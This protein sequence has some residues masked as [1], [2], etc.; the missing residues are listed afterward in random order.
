MSATATKDSAVQASFA[1]LGEVLSKYG[2]RA[3]A[4]RAWDGSVWE[5]EAGQSARFT[6]VLQH[7][8]AVRKMFWPPRPYTLGE[9]YISD[10]ID[11]EGDIHA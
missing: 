6:L 1:F 8:G 2:P 7:P 9:A 4:V 10:D 3:F 5:P 11:I